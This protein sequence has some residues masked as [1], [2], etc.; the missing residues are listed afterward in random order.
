MPIN[1]WGVSIGAPHSSLLSVKKMHKLSGF[2]HTGGNMS[3]NQQDFHY[4]ETQTLR[5]EPQFAGD[6][7]DN[8]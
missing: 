5:H 8:A 3:D 2:V 4:L 6:V 1:T 7:S